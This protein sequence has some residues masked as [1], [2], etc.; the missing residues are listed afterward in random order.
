M[1]SFLTL[2]TECL[3]WYYGQN[4]NKSCSCVESKTEI[5]DKVT[6]SCTCKYGWEG[7]NCESDINECD[8]NIYTCRNNSHCFNSNGSYICE[9]D[10]GFFD[11]NDLNGTCQGII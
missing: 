9:C 2:Y 6:G 5:C 3:P 10:K 1:E 8:Q 11:G 4:C 7:A